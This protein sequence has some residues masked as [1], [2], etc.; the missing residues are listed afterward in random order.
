M[1]TLILDAEKHVF[2]LLNIDLER[3]YVY[4][5]LA[6]TQRV[7]KKIKELVGNLKCKKCL[8]KI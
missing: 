7:V 1:S 2:K 8:L 3:K 5:N 6:H 4:H